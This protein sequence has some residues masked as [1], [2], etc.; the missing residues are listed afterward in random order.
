MASLGTPTGVSVWTALGGGF[1]PGGE[2]VGWVILVLV[3]IRYI[4]RPIEPVE[5]HPAIPILRLLL[6]ACPCRRR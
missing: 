1:Q 2:F 6:R 5:L 3:N 4:M